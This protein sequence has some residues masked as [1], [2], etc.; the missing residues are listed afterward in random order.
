M[1]KI[2]L[3]IAI[4][5]TVNNFAFSQEEKDTVKEKNRKYGV[6]YAP[7]KATDVY[8]VL[9]NFAEEDSVR[10]YGVEFNIN[11]KALILTAAAPV[12]ALFSI[13]VIPQWD[14]DNDGMYEIEFDKKI[15]GL[16][17]KGLVMDDRSIVNGLNISWVGNIGG[18][19]NG[20]IISPI[21]NV[22]DVVGL[23]VAPMGNHGFYCRGVQIGLFNSCDN[24]K[25]FQVGLWNKNQKR[26][27]PIINWAF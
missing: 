15:Y 8:G 23:T 12:V 27:L 1:K 25:G 17:I 7:S 3:T 5:I 24:L 10:V 11:P 26:K 20:I 9:F 6:W 13:I 19:T 2:F 22:S 21:V 16:Q 14:I 18:K 4:F